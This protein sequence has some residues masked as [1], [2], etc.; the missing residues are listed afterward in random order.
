MDSV[1][2]GQGVIAN[3]AAEQQS[4][5]WMEALLS[6]DAEATT[7]V[8]GL[9]QASGAADTQQLRQMVRQAQQTEAARP[10]EGG[11]GS[12]DDSGG[13]AT[14]A[15]AARGGSYAPRPTAK[16]VAARRQLRRLLQQLAQAQMGSDADEE[17]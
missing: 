7:T 12:S 5:L 8:F 11:G 10:E 6:S 1:R 4:Q 17:A 3:P 13:D 14:A 15:L 16:A 9:A 2:T